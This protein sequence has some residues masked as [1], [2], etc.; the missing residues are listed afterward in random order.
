MVDCGGFRNA[1]RHQAA[2]GPR[3]PRGKKKKGAAQLTRPGKENSEPRER[4]LT[5]PVCPLQCSSGCT[6]CMCAP[7]SYQQSVFRYYFIPWLDHLAKLKR[8]PFRIR[9]G[10]Q[11]WHHGGKGSSRNVAVSSEIK[12]TVPSEPLP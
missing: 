12:A 5:L 9:E 4:P 6:V 1:H 11:M 2:G 8:T 7:T 10:V 3:K